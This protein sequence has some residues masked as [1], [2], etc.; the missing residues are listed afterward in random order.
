MPCASYLISNLPHT[1][2]IKS[3]LIASSC[4][5]LIHLS[6]SPSFPCW[7]SSCLFLAPPPFPPQSIL[8]SC[9]YS[10]VTLP[11]SLSAWLA[12]LI[13]IFLDCWFTYRS[14]RSSRT[15]FLAL[16]PPLL[17]LIVFYPLKA[18][19]LLQRVFEV[20]TFP[21]ILGWLSV[22]AGAGV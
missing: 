21:L 8:W 4:S 7:A 6:Y 2:A 10:W 3:P 9:T 19:A 16:S 11:L 15:Q 17:L 13:F 18:M 20:L 22:K 14:R 12:F 1:R 5:H